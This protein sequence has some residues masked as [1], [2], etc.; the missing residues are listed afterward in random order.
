MG[1]CD[2]PYNKKYNKEIVLDKK[3]KVKN[4]IEYFRCFN[5]YRD[6]TKNKPFKGSA[7]F[8][9]LTK[10]YILLKVVYLKKNIY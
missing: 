4:F 3:I 10:N 9:H 1:W 5:C 6:N 7:I 2:D 8:I